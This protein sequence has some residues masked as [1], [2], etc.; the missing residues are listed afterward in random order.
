MNKHVLLASLP[1]LFAVAVWGCGGSDDATGPD[2]GDHTS[3]DKTCLGCHSSESDLKD[4][5]GIT[6]KVTGSTIYDKDDG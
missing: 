1:L 2:G 5:L 6:A 4:A 3:T